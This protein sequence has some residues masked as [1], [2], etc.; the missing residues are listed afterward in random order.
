MPKQAAPAAQASAPAG[1]ATNHSE[2][3]RLAREFAAMQSDLGGLVYEMASRDHFRL[4]VLSQQ[5]AKLRLVDAELARAEGRAAP[6]A[7]GWQLSELLDAAS[8]RRRVLRRLRQSAGEPTGGCGAGVPGAGRAGTRP[9]RERDD[10]GDRP[11]HASD[12]AELLRSSGR[13]LEM[14]F[15]RQLNLL[16]ARPDRASLVRFASFRWAALPITNRRWTAPMA[17]TAL[18]FGIFAG[19]AIGAGEEASR[20]PEG[21]IMVQMPPAADD[22]VAAGSGKPGNSASP[23]SAGSGQGSSVGPP[24]PQDLGT[25]TP[26]AP[27]T[28]FETPPIAP[29]PL[30]PAVSTAPETATDDATTVTES[31]DSV[32]V[33][34]KLAGTIV[35][36]NPRAGSYTIAAKTGT[37]SSI[38]TVEPPNVAE[39]VE[40][41]ARTLANGTFDEG[42]K[43]KL[44]GR[45]KRV[46]LT[47]TVT[48]RDPVANAYTVSGVGSSLLVTVGPETAPPSLGAKVELDARFVTS[49]FEAEFIPATP[50]EKRKRAEPPIPGCGPSGGSPNVPE[51]TLRQDAV[52]VITEENLSDDTVSAPVQLEGIVQGVCRSERKLI[53]SADDVDESGADITLNAPG[54]IGLKKIDP[55]EAVLATAVISDAGIYRLTALASDDRAK[56]ADNPDL[57][58]TSAGDEPTSEEGDAAR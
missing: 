5:A 20:G 46:S 12:P 44:D 23:T 21:P 6:A 39:A 15:P 38:H 55:G 11:R 14:K 3:E 35:R 17:A 34:T 33:L 9:A 52:K 37:L 28:G 49:P 58:Q 8:R 29:A 32:P 16:A 36:Q 43:R 31:A 26:A 2:R 30:A 1:A 27:A 10:R 24:P 47:G 53:V 25:I 56:R 42:S 18:G 4:D 54:D 50:A 48:Y 41:E 51:Q 22:A 57:I 19:V 13:W 45:R 7:V 40:V